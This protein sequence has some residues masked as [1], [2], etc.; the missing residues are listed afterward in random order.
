MY[1]YKVSLY[2]IGTIMMIMMMPPKEPAHQQ[3]RSVGIL[4]TMCY[5]VDAKR[6]NNKDENDSCNM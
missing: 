3:K 6:E 2:N 5:V 4:H 1:Y